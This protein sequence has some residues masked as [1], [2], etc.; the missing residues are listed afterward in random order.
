MEEIS[1]IDPEKE[2]FAVEEELD[3][4]RSCESPS[5]VPVSE[6]SDSE[7]EE[8][9]PESFDEEEKTEPTKHIEN[10]GGNLSHLT[11]NVP[12]AARVPTGRLTK[13]EMAEIRSIF[14]D[15]D[16][17]EIHKLYKRVTQ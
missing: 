17:S 10:K 4:E 9:F 12:R 14:G 6:L 16:D 8:Y 7:A 3:R 5:E 13:Q 15:M 1:N 11:S 2:N